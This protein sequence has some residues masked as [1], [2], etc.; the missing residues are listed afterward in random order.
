MAVC[1]WSIEGDYV[2]ARDWLIKKF[3]HKCMRVT[4]WESVIG[5]F[6]P[7]RGQ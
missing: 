7:N 6:G 1:D 3:A 5:Q 4:T 2:E